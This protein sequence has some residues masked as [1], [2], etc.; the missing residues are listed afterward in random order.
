VLTQTSSSGRTWRVGTLTYTFGGLAALFCW[1][2]WGDFAWSIRDR[3]VPLVMQVLFKKFG[4]SDFLVGFLF[5]SLPGALGLIVWPV[6]GYKSDRLRTRWGRRIPFLVA[7]TP[8]VVLSVVGLAF[9]PQL[10]GVLHHLLGRYSPGPDAAGV[11]ILGTLWTFFEISLVTAN[12][13]FDGLVNDVVPQVV[14]GRF[15]GLF[16]VVSLFVAI[17]FFF[18]LTGEAQAHFSWIFLGVGVIYGAGLTLMCVNVKEGQYPP[19]PEDSGGRASALSAVKTYF[20]D[21]FG[22][23]FY[24]WFFAANILGSIA[25][26]PFDLYS[27]F[28]AG[29]FSLNANDPNAYGKYLALTYFCSLC[30]AYP[31]GSLVDRFHPLRVSLVAVALY[32][33][34]MGYGYFFVHNALTFA[35]ALVIHGVVAGIHGTT[36]ASLAQRLLP[37]AKFAEINS[38]GGVLRNLA[39]IVLGMAMG[40]FLDYKHHDYRYT[41]LAGFVIDVVALIA[42][43][44]LYRKFMDLGGPEHYVA[45]E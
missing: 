28:Y 30:L 16:R 26:K 9:S 45:P 39:G 20:K 3:V 37:R 38:V 25:T 24:L 32:T 10:G 42:F 22:H 27:L 5:A 41:F 33:G 1:L 11:I 36:V 44:V 12:S 4:A 43:V 18:K 6:V 7:T 31:L 2:L 14:L 13:V 15:Y 34:A 29:T 17:P 19:P 21:G 8:M 23:S 35:V 40:A